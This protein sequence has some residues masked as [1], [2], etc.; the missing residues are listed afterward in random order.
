[1]STPTP[2]LSVA[3]AKSR[4]KNHFLCYLANLNKIWGH[5]ELDEEGCLSAMLKLLVRELNLSSAAL[6]LAG[7]SGSN[8]ICACHFQPRSQPGG[9]FRVRSCLQHVAP[10]RHETHP[11]PHADTAGPLESI[12]EVIRHHH[13]DLARLEVTLQPGSNSRHARQLIR[14]TARAALPAV[15]ALAMRRELDQRQHAIDFGHNLGHLAHHLKNYLTQFEGSLRLLHTARER[16]DAKMEQEL[17]PILER[18]VGKIQRMAGDLMKAAPAGDCL[19]EPID[20]RDVLQ[21]VA[22]DLRPQFIADLIELT[23][24]LPEQPVYVLADASQLHDCAVNLLL[25]AREAL[26]DCHQLAKC[27]RLSLWR[28]DQL[29]RI[30]IWDNGPGIPAETVN[31]IFQPFFT[32]KPGGTGL[33]LAMVHRAMLDMGGAI[34]VHSEPGLSTCFT[35]HLP[36]TPPDPAF[37]GI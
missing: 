23:F 33:G 37:A 36:L 24:A 12:S 20:A 21:R 35:L 16:G 11:H 29:C 26:A 13:R 8:F 1:M 6:H 28:E 9:I 34:E 19:I 15:R 32:T 5:P 25:N 14:Q 30:E 2:A 7:L 4:S 3:M 17:W 18:S 22:A 27:A 10:L 31:K